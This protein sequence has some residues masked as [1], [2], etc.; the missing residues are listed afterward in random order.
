MNQ[1]QWL[2]IFFLSSVLF[3]PLISEESRQSTQLLEIQDIQ[4]SANQYTFTTHCDFPQRLQMNWD[5]ESDSN[6]GII[7]EG[8]IHRCDGK[9]FSTGL[10]E[11][12]SVELLFMGQTDVQ[13]SLFLKS[14]SLGNITEMTFNYSIPSENLDTESMFVQPM[15][16]AQISQNLGIG[17]EPLTYLIDNLVGDYFYSSTGIGDLSS[18]HPGNATKGPMYDYNTGLRYSGISGQVLTALTPC[19]VLP[20]YYDDVYWV[21]WGHQQLTPSHLFC[22]SIMTE[23][24]FSKSSSSNRWSPNYSQSLL[25]DSFEHIWD[26]NGNCWGNIRT[27]PPTQFV[28]YY[29]PSTNPQLNMWVPTQEDWF[30]L[31]SK[32]IHI[33]KI[34]NTS[35]ISISASFNERFI[36]RGIDIANWYKTY[37]T[38]TWIANNSSNPT[39]LAILPTQYNS[40]G[41]FAECVQQTLFSDPSTCSSTLGSLS[42]HSIRSSLIYSYQQNAMGGQSYF[43]QNGQI[44][45]ELNVIFSYYQQNGQRRDGQCPAGESYY[46]LSWID[47]LRTKYDF[48]FHDREAVIFS[49]N[50][51]DS[52]VHPVTGQVSEIMLMPAGPTEGSTQMVWNYSNITDDGFFYFKAKCDKSYFGGSSWTAS[53]I[54]YISHQSYHYTRLE[55]Y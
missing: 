45:F 49:N 34:T 31:S 54:G 48:G 28:R 40:T 13:F 52:S 17:S 30:K 16:Q 44:K 12:V 51:N 18:C 20:T 1:S 33:S 8:I 47:L 14:E 5:Q 23:I 41:W 35:N 42:N 11:G 26:P 25:F 15:F 38:A 46:W 43:Q 32:T 53:P 6:G 19:D 50:P 10:V 27:D 3:S 24:G 9:S 2:V 7:I 37:P 39:Q 29:D 21:N 22:E 55:V 4:Q 36:F